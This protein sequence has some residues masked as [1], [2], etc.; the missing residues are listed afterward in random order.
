[1]D[2]TE[3]TA[4]DGFILTR[5]WQES[6]QGIV[7]V[8]WL[9]SSQGPVRVTISEQEAVCFFPASQQQLV[10]TTLGAQ[11]GWRISSTSLRDFQ[12][13]EVA[14]LYAKRRRLLLDCCDR[15]QARGVTLLESDIKPTDRFLMER[16]ITGGLT[17]TATASQI[18][19]NESFVSLQQAKLKL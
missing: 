2:T 9:C 6:P 17:V 10:A 11:S 7:L 14:A 12:R 5:Q 15:L 19:Q 13:Q 18:Q 8:F 4:I 3:T 16:F 1:M